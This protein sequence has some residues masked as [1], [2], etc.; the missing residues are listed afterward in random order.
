MEYNF[1]LVEVKRSTIKESATNEPCNENESPKLYL[2]ALTKIQLDT[3]VIT[4]GSFTSV[5]GGIKILSIQYLRTWINV[6]QL[7]L[8]IVLIFSLIT[9]AIPN[10]YAGLKRKNPIVVESVVKK[11]KH[12]A[13]FIPEL[14]HVVAL[15]DERIPFT[16]L[17]QE[18]CTIW[19]RF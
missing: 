3:F 18:V 5:I 14:A 17:A 7:H 15:C 12:P 2:K 16:T 13:Y 8:W 1:Y 19:N 9:D 4:H 6:H 10:K 11:V